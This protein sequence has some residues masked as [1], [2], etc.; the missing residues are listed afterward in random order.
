MDGFT[1]QNVPK[2]KVRTTTRN[3]NTLQLHLSYILCSHMLIG[4]VQ[5]SYEEQ[6]F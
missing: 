4:S 3:K 1:I 5:D 6:E 2:Q